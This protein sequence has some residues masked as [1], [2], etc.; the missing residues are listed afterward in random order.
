MPTGQAGAPFEGRRQLDGLALKDQR[1][2][3]EITTQ[4]LTELVDVI[5]AASQ[6]QL[7]D[8]LTDLLVRP[9]P[10]KRSQDN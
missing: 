5:Y 8:M 6:L 4:E 10:T 7:D 2:M 1:A 3:E 9:Y